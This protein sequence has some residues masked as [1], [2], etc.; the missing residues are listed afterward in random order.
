MCIQSPLKPDWSVFPVSR[1]NSGTDGLTYTQMCIRVYVHMLLYIVLYFY[2]CFFFIL[3]MFFLFARQSMTDKLYM[4]S[5]Q[6]IVYSLE[7][8]YIV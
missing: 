5:L 3:D 2:F 4:Y 6:F 7:I 8:V 1:L